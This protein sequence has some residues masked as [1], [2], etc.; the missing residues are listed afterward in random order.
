MKTY[1]LSLSYVVSLNLRINVFVFSARSRSQAI[2]FTITAI[3]KD[4]FQ[5]TNDRCDD[6]SGGSCRKSEQESPSK[7]KPKQPHLKFFIN[8]LLRIIS[9]S[10]DQK[11]VT[12]I[13]NIEY[14]W[15]EHWDL[16]I[17]HFYFSNPIIF[18]FKCQWFKKKQ[19]EEYFSRSDEINVPW[20]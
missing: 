15:F 17:F 7:L 2:F 12:S 4:C 10:A 9:C 20:K 3:F 8:R 14:V 5:K 6:F 11:K 19:A 1:L 18:S 13:C 16:I